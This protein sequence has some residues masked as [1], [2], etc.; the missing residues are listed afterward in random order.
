LKY[1]SC[2]IPRVKSKLFQLFKLSVLLCNSVSI[3]RP[4]DDMMMMM[5]MMKQCNLITRQDEREKSK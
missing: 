3:I 1:E 5:M 2:G 4:R